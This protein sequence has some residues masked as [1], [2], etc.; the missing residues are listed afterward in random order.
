MRASVCSWLHES[1]FYPVNVPAIGILPPEILALV[2]HYAI[3]ELPLNRRRPRTSR[4]YFALGQHPRSGPTSTPSP[5][6]A[7]LLRLY[8]ENAGTLPVSLPSHLDRLSTSHP[9][10][11]EFLVGQQWAILVRKLTQ[12]HLPNRQRL[13]IAVPSPA[14]TALCSPT[15]P[16]SLKSSFPGTS[17]HTRM[18]TALQLSFLP[19]YQCLKSLVRCTNLIDFSGQPH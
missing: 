2:L 13:K 10:T 19:V 1:L 7:A 15:H 8:S 16:I 6:D 12:S 9:T 17:F 18:I 5:T 14:P 4:W 11:S 3:Q